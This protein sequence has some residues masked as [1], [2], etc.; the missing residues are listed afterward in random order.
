[1][2]NL[3]KISESLMSVFSSDYLSSGQYLATK[4]YI[5]MVKDYHLTAFSY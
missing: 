5:L 4:T 2:L 3:R 1:M